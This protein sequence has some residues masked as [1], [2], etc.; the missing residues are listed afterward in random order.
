MHI[1]C[2]YGVHGRETTKYTVIYG[3]YKRFWPT[4]DT[5]KAR[6]YDLL[7]RTAQSGR[8]RKSIQ[9]RVVR[10]NFK[11]RSSDSQLLSRTHTQVIIQLSQTNAHGTFAALSWCSCSQHKCR[12]G[13]N[14]VYTVYKRYFWQ[15][16]HQINGHIRCIYTVVA[17]PT[18]MQV[19]CLR[20]FPQNRSPNPVLIKSIC[21]AVNHEMKTSLLPAG[22]CNTHP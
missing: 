17:N 12:D 10:N 15:G 8:P 6:L 13:Q 18:Q 9:Q 3:V 21:S 20:C 22:P 4:L 19:S 2:T 7:Y 11:R 14:H 5:H 1:Q 16:N